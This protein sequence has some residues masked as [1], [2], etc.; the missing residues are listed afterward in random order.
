PELVIG[1]IPVNTNQELENYLE[2]VKTFNEVPLNPWMKNILQIAGGDDGQKDSFKEIMEG[3]NGLFAKSELAFDTTLISRASEDVINE[4]QA[5]QIKKEI[6]EGKM[7]VN[8]LGHGSPSV[9]DMSGWEA[10]NLNNQGKYGVLNTLS[11]NT[12]AF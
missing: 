7:W 11:C 9:I 6:N 1:R 4:T 2:K 10:P 5:D 8:F 3:L 12:S